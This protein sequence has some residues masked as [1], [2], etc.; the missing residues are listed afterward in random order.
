MSKVSFFTVTEDSSSQALPALHTLV[1]RTCLAT[2][3]GSSERDFEFIP[4]PETC[5]SAAVANAWKA[6][7]SNGQVFRVRLINAMAEALLKGYVVLYHFDAD[8]P[9]SRISGCA[10]FEKFQRLV[11]IPVSRA[12]KAHRARPVSDAEV[13]Q[14]MR[15]F[16]LVV[17]AYSV[18][19]W[20]YQSA[21][22]ALRI[23]AK[24][25]YGKKTIEK[26][27]AWSRTP[28]LLDEEVAV[29]DQ[30]NLSNR[31]NHELA[32]SFPVA[33]TRG[34]GLSFDLFVR[35]LEAC[36]SVESKLVGVRL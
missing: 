2:F 6:G 14:L 5:S 19:A 20:Y 32:D 10:H 11:W 18:E 7:T 22:A 13:R 33:K 29:K 34:L 28:H 36:D 12:L 23:A 3:P 1:S 27:R 4:R 26:L 30:T 31:H 35:A 17:P 9:W 15:S 25:K 16:V 8:E 21:E 24:R